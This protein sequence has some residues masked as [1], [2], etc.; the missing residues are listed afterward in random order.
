MKTGNAK[1][2][3]LVNAFSGH[4]IGIDRIVRYTGLSEKSVTMYVSWARYGNFK[5]RKLCV[6]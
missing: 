3:T 5:N 1:L 6:A 2:Q 4:K